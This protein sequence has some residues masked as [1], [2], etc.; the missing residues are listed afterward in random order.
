MTGNSTSFTVQ[1]RYSAAGPVQAANWPDGFI[2]ENV[3]ISVCGM[4]NPL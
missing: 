1:N 2:A 3:R 4:E